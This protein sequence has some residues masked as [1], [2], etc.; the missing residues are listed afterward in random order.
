MGRGVREEE[1]RRKG[2]K[3]IHSCA[4]SQWEVGER[5]FLLKNSE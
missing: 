1:K 5:L 3:K 4:M 2:G